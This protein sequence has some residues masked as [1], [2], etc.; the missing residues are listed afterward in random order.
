MFYVDHA[1][2][3]KRDESMW[4]WLGSCDVKGSSLGGGEHQNRKRL[5]ANRDNQHEQAQGEEAEEALVL[6]NPVSSAFGDRFVGWQSE[7]SSELDSTSEQQRS[8]SDADDLDAR[9]AFDVS[10]FSS[11]STGSHAHSFPSIDSEN[12]HVS[13]QQSEAK[14]KRPSLLE[15]VL[16]GF[17]HCAFASDDVDMMALWLGSD[18]GSICDESHQLSD[19]TLGGAEESNSSSEQPSSISRSASVEDLES[20]S[21]CDSVSSLSSLSVQSG[22]CAISSPRR[23]ENIPVAPATSTTLKDRNGDSISTAYPKYWSSHEFVKPKVPAN[24]YDPAPRIRRLKPDRDATRRNLA[25]RLAYPHKPRSFNNTTNYQLQF[26]TPDAELFVKFSELHEIL[27]DHVSRRHGFFLDVGCGT[28]TICREMALHGYN[29]VVGIDIAATKLEFQRRQCQGL[30]DFARFQTMDASELKFPDEL[31]DCVFTKA[32]LDIVASN[33]VYEPMIDDDLDELKRIL[34]E[35][36]RCLQPGGVWIVVSCYNSHSTDNVGS[37]GPSDSDA[38]DADTNGRLYKPWWQWKGVVEFIERSYDLVKSYGAGVPLIRHGKRVKP[39]VV[40]VYKR[41]EASREQRLSRLYRDQKEES[42]REREFEL[43][44]QWHLEKRR[45][46]AEE[47]LITCETRQM[48]VEDAMSRCSEAELL[49]VM[50]MQKR[51]AMRAEIYIAILA[52]DRALMD[53]EDV[54]AAAVRAEATALLMF[55]RTVLLGAAES[56]VA[57]AVMKERERAA[58]VV[59]VAAKESVAEERTDAEA[60][61][62]PQCEALETATGLAVPNSDLLVAISALGVSD[63]E[64]FTRSTPPSANLVAEGG[65]QTSAKVSIDSAIAIP[66]EKSSEQ[67]NFPAQVRPIAPVASDIHPAIATVE[68]VSGVEDDECVEDNSNGATFPCAQEAD[69]G[70]VAGDSNETSP[71]MTG[72]SETVG[73]STNLADNKQE[74]TAIAKENQLILTTNPQPELAHGEISTLSGAKAESEGHK[75]SIAHAD[76]AENGRGSEDRHLIVPTTAAVGD[77]NPSRST[78]H[79]G[80]P[81]NTPDNVSIRSS[82]ASATTLVDE[83]VPRCTPKDP[84]SDEPGAQSDGRMLDTEPH[85]RADGVVADDSSA[86]DLGLANVMEPADENHCSAAPTVY[87]LLSEDN[88]VDIQGRDSRPSELDDTLGGTCTVEP[89]QSPGAKAPCNKTIET[90]SPDVPI[91]P[92]QAAES[93]EEPASSAEQRA[94][95]DITS[96]VCFE[97]LEQILDTIVS[98][99]GV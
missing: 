85:C 73:S 20:S 53:V 88:E 7:S 64:S 96:R 52:A 68:Q 24:Q 39:F 9:K 80:N 92:P 84:R 34:R 72:E 89:M 1:N 76:C 59:V 97:A 79:G 30:H 36:W 12:H 48:V 4:W 10:S 41:K 86:D 33:Y 69:K 14:D 22:V 56:A 23:I 16:P 19:S 65:A 91:P 21:N 31:F 78:E 43:V 77:L 5:G 90:H 38:S 55:I 42:R 87:L 51:E 60:A 74:A 35:I 15:A 2:G 54:L 44:T 58:A 40:L 11:Y 61:T 6:K 70:D 98:L 50:K 83:R 46:H 26:V 62:T 45:W 71:T 27:I 13:V 37:L 3:E 8:S 63:T 18:S 81:E 47:A 99:D 29:N 94:E 95:E 17:T 32:T 57:V 82:S 25:K 28:S 49:Y 93:Q 67:R 75:S 66:V